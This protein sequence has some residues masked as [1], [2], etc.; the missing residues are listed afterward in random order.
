MGVVGGDM[1]TTIIINCTCGNCIQAE[2]E[3]EGTI[4]CKECYTVWRRIYNPHLEIY[5]VVIES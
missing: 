5:E 3:G 2:I 4:V 1:P